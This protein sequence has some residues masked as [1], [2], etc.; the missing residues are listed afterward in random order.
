MFLLF[1]GYSSFSIV[2][3]ERVRLLEEFAFFM[4]IFERTC[5]ATWKNLAF[6]CSVTFKYSFVDFSVFFDG[7]LWK[8]CIRFL[9]VEYFV[10]IEIFYDVFEENMKK[11]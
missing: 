11:S 8:K 5:L 2:K 4:Y 3:F 7:T 9:F 10:Q 6:E 1:A